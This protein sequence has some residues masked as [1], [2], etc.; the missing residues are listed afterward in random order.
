MDPS[1][2]L[3]LYGSRKD[4]QIKLRGQRIECKEIEHVLYSCTAFKVNEVVVTKYEHAGEE[5]LIAY[6]QI[7]EEESDVTQQLL[8]LHCEQHLPT[9]MIPS[10][11]VFLKTIPRNSNGKIDR[12]ML[13]K[14]DFI[15]HID[16][17]YATVEPETEAERIILLL[18]KQILNIDVITHRSNFFTLGGTS[19]LFMRLVQQYQTKFS[20]EQK[21]SM[22]AYFFEKPTFG[23]HV[24]L[25]E[26]HLSSPLSYSPSIKM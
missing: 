24:R 3:L 5:Y 23:E 25:V 12:K 8:H 7:L 9:F 14:P 21:S 15:K 22:M 13:P 16:T 18:W 19:L 2:G 1:S 4:F 6:V 17:H 11:F 20:A 26:K 10:Y